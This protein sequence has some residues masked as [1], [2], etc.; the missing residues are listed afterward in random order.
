MSLVNN[1][2]Y[3]WVLN[4]L[5]KFP[6]NV[7][8]AHFTV[9]CTNQGLLSS[10]SPHANALE[11]LVYLFCYRQ[12]SLARWIFVYGILG[13]H[14]FTTGQYQHKSTKMYVIEWVCTY[15]THLERFYA[16]YGKLGSTYLL[17]HILS[18]TLFYFTEK[19]SL[20]TRSYN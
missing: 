16:E 15:E 14:K 6:F 13:N 4:F 1:L 7:S 5:Y 8:N 18:M 17:L 19:K 9:H 3:Y 12:I 11:M 20:F 2:I 10:H